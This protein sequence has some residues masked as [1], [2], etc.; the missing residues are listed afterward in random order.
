MKLVTEEDTRSC[1]NAG[2][3]YT[4]LDFMNHF[5]E[6]V[7]ASPIYM[8]E[9]QVFTLLVLETDNKESDNNNK[10]VWEDIVWELFDC[11]IPT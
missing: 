4:D 11:I 5:T 1:T 8:F 9:N 3:S 2:A 6:G 10:K 7:T